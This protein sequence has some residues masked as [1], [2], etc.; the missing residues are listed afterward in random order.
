MKNYVD[1]TFLE[2]IRA[3]MVQWQISIG[4]GGISFVCAKMVATEKKCLKTLH[5]FCA[6][7]LLYKVNH[8]LVMAPIGELWCILGHPNSHPSSPSRAV[9]EF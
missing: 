2:E 5:F 6:D 1:T 8:M 9:L 7:F 3:K 4:F